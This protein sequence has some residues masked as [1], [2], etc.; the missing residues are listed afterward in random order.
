MDVD[1]AMAYKDLAQLDYHTLGSIGALGEIAK[2]SSPEWPAGA[3]G[4]YRR[5]SSAYRLIAP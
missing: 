5:Q 2:Q 3:G 1:G 4:G